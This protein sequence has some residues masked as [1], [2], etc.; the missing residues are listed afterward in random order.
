MQFLIAEMK[1][2]LAI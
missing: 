1:Q 2:S